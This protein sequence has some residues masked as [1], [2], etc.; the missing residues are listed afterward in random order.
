MW[1]CLSKNDGRIDCVLMG[2]ISSAKH[3][4][5]ISYFGKFIFARDLMNCCPTFSKLKT[6]SLSVYWW[7]A[8]DLDP[9]ACIL[10]N[11]PVLEKLSLKLFSKGPDHEVE[12]KGR[13]SPMEGPSAIS[14]HL[15]MVEIKC[16]VVD[17][18][19]LKVLKLLSTFNIRFGFL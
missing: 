7:E 16:N 12:M 8:P 1:N 3:L 17:E 2:G 10:Q 18:K 9:L 19:I 14:E 15:N 11:S 6:L 13:Y 4:A 5:L